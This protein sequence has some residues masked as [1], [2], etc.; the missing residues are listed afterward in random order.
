M[1]VGDRAALR[2]AAR[3][4]LQEQASHMPDLELR[5]VDVPEAGHD[6]TALFAAIDRALADI[7]A[8]PVR[9]RRADGRPGPTTSLPR[10]LPAPSTS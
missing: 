10:R 1:S 9:H 6:G 4:R 3:A 2:D 8:P 7:P 5:T